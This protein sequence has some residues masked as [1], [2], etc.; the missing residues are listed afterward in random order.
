MGLSVLPSAANF[1]MVPD[2]RASTLAAELRTRGV[3]VRWFGGLPAAIPDFA[4]AQ[5][6]AL[7]IGVGPWESMHR[8]LDALAE[9]L[10]CA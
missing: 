6:T 4:L 8:L 2:S 3:G 7:R 9:V 5:G 10:P 1:V